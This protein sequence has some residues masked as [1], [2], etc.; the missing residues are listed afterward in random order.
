M[1]FN[2]NLIHIWHL[3][4]DRSGRDGTRESDSDGVENKIVRNLILLPTAIHTSKIDS[5]T[6][7]S[8]Q[9]GWRIKGL[10]PRDV[11][12]LQ[13]ALPIE[14][15]LSQASIGHVGRFEYLNRGDQKELAFVVQSLVFDFDGLFEIVIDNQEFSGPTQ[16]LYPRFLELGQVCKSSQHG[17]ISHS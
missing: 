2:I 3:A 10:K 4:V 5:G 14:H 7:L 11:L 17:I 1:G 9:L 15:A 6:Y 12:A 13:L 8:G 16:L